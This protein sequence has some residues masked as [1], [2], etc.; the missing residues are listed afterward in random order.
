MGGC[1]LVISI[2]KIVALKLDTVMI[3]WRK[4]KKKKRLN[5]Q[6][7]S[8]RTLNRYDELIEYKFS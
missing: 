2:K 8:K 6:R 3:L 4:K 1:L 7:P 5:A